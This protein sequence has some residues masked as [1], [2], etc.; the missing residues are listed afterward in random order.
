MII[1]VLAHQKQQKNWK[2]YLGQR[3]SNSGTYWIW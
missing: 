3:L 2:G 1:C